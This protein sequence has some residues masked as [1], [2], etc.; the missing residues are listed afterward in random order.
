MQEISGLLLVSPPADTTV[1][2]LG[3]FGGG[4]IFGGDDVGCVGGGPTTGD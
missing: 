4:K 3:R 2:C 1:R